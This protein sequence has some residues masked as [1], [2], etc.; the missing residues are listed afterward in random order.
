MV[1]SHGNIPTMGGDSCPAAAPMFR[2]LYQGPLE[3]I[4]KTAP[5]RS[6]KSLIDNTVKCA[7]EIATEI[8]RAAART[9][10]PAPQR[11]DVVQGWRTKGSPMTPP[12][13]SIGCGD[14]KQRRAATRKPIASPSREL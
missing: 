1:E 9:G 14:E 12:G 11:W 2:V 5:K 6:A 7:H 13:L 10:Q 3:Q 8:F 4:P